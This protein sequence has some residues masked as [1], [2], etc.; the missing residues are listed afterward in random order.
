M[1][2]SYEQE[3]QILTVKFKV[4]LSKP[5]IYWVIDVYKQC[6]LNSIK[7]K[8]PTMKRLIFTLTITLLMAGATFAQQKQGDMD[9]KKQQMQEM[10]QDS[11]MRTMMMEHM[12]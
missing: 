3:V 10:M 11:T 12:A 6:E 8:V 4:S 7:F 2:C 9:K 1:E 5:S